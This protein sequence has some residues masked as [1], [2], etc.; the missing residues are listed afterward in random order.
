MRFKRSESMD[1]LNGSMAQTVGPALRDR[2][3]DLRRLDTQS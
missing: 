2:G 3:A 1:A